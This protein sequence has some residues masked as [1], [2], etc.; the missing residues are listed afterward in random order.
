MSHV[1]RSTNAC[2]KD[3][4]YSHC[5]AYTG[6][7]RPVANGYD[8]DVFLPV[9]LITLPG[10]ACG[11]AGGIAGLLRLKL[12]EITDGGWCVRGARVWLVLLG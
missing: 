4:N 11:F 1:Q 9:R 8:A 2:R 12:E 5:G 3:C 10:E 7:G 6:S